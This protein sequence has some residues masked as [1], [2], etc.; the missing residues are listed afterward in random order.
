MLVSCIS[1]TQHTFNSITWLQKLVDYFTGERIS[2]NLFQSFRHTYILILV[3]LFLDS[4]PR[5]GTKQTI[6]EI[7]T[8]SGRD[9]DS[10]R[11]GALA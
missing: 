7:E 2:D 10:V 6:S 9:A 3:Y 11:P 5:E 4:R 8:A 1:C